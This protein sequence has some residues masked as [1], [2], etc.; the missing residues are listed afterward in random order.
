MYHDENHVMNP[1]K[2]ILVSFLGSMCAF[3]QV[4]VTEIKIHADPS[5]KVRPNESIALQV[6]AYGRSGGQ[7]GR[8]RQ[9][10]AELKMLDSNGGWLSK[11]YRFQGKDDEEFVEA[12]QS[13][14]GKIFGQLTGQ[15]VMQD[16][17]IYTAPDKAGRYRVQAKLSGKVATLTIEVTPSAPSNRPAEQFAF[18]AE[19][20]SLDPYRD[21]A[22]HWAPLI[23]QETWFQH[24]ADYIAR[25][26]YDGDWKGNNN[27]DN[28]D[29]GASQAYVH[30]AAIE[31]ATHWFL[32]Y[33]IFHPRDY[34]D[35]CVAGSCHENDNEGLI[36]TVARDGS[37]YGKLLTMETLAHNNIYSFTA[38]NSV[39]NGQ[40]D[41]D[42][43]VEF[44][45]HRPVVFI[46]SG[47]H[48][49]Y[50]TRS[51]HAR[52]DVANENFTAGTGVTYVY[53]GIAERPKHGNAR[54][55]GYELLSIYQEWWIRS[56]D[57][58]TGMFDDFFTYSPSGNRPRAAWSSLAGAFFG[59]AQGANM[60]KPFW[61]WHD[62]KTKKSG[63]LGTGQ[64]SLDPAYSTSRNLRFRGQFS[65]DYTFNPYLAVNGL[66]ESTPPPND[67]ISRA[68]KAG[69]A[70]QPGSSRP[71]TRASRTSG[72]RGSRETVSANPVPGDP[73][74][75]NG[76]FEITVWVDG[77]AD[78]EVQGSRSTV[79]NLQG[80]DPRSMDIPNTP[81]PM[82]NLRSLNLEIRS[83]RGKAT[84]T[85]RPSASNSFT[86]RIR[87][88]DPA[89]SG[90]TYNLVLVWSR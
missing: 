81:M 59:R 77:M 56:G 6:R 85:Q 42:G 80:A 75:T 57:D 71:K 78:V 3:A 67:R 21:L 12:Y 55:V 31:T 40:H 39:R 24:K 76:A 60:A 9:D 73:V 23:A 68:G 16:A 82:A 61:G 64:W 19:P 86:T 90:A 17:A 5:A 36:L 83:G 25:F 79:T 20:V 1:A 18:D 33:N 32:L 66:S 8:V 34:S 54:F 4:A 13:Q 28:L 88:E 87:I 69:A 7:T 41:I 43:E 14:A 53:K 2:L 47:G 30:Y 84:I 65:T 37:A 11:P 46:E 22:E 89:R 27:W 70:P 44:H 38:D 49:V 48:G 35:K 63:A 15:Y 62:N 52:Y 74:P 29:A 51:S 58:G 45:G 26:D 72:S 50:G 10:G